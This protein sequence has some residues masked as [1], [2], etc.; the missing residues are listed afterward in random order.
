MQQVKAEE[1]SAL[2]FGSLHVVSFLYEEELGL[3]VDLCLTFK[4][5]SFCLHC[6]ASDSIRQAVHQA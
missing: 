2:L 6:T 1:G 3:Q 5:L 4:R